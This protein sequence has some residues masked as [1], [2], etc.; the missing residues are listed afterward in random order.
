MKWNILYN[1]FNHWQPSIVWGADF[2]IID[3]N[4][5]DFCCFLLKMNYYLAGNESIKKELVKALNQYARDRSVEQL[6]QNLKRI[7]KTPVERKLLRDI[8]YCI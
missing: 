5:V 1:I 8:R 2:R 3:S 6:A 4:V 7:L